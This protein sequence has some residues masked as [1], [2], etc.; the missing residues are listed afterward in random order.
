MVRRREERR[1]LPVP[2][3]VVLTVLVALFGL[4]TFGAAMQQRRR[5]ANLLSVLFFLGVTA[6]AVVVTIY[7]LQQFWTT[8]LPPTPLAVSQPVV[9]TPGGTPPP[10]PPG[11]QEALASQL[12]YG[13][14]V[15]E[16][17]C[18]ACHQIAADRPA[19]PP[20]VNAATGA[21]IAAPSL[22]AIARNPKTTDE[23]L[24]AF[25]KLPHP[26]MLDRSVTVTSGDMPYLTAYILSLR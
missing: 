12:V 6:L 24:R 19:P 18:A 22:M 2:W 10:M 9:A 5:G 1:G 26:P 13:K 23:S 17:N 11:P 25:L 14:A 8:P 4:I 16:Q 20:I 15:A 7:R 3:D 21:T